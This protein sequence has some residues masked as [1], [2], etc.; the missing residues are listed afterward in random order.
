MSKSAKPKS[1][2]VVGDKLELE[3][4]RL[5]RG[6]KAVGRSSD[7]QVVFVI[8]AAPGETVRAEITAVSSRF[9]EARMTD[10][11]KPSEFRVKPP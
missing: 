8:G 11:I 5:A 4:L 10:V 1:S 7:G 3:T 6:G 9:V 2:L